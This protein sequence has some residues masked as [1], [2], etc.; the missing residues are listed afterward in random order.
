MQSIITQPDDTLSRMYQ[1]EASLQEKIDQTRKAVTAPV[2]GLVSFYLDG[3]ETSITV[4]GIAAMTPDKVK[5]LRDKILSASQSFEN[6]DIVAVGQPVCRIVNPGK[7][8]AVIVM[9]NSENRFVE[10]T[11]CDVT[12]DGLQKTVT[13]KVL[14]VATQGD[15]F[16]AVLEV[17]EGVKEI[18]SLRLVGGH[19]GQDIEGFRVPLN[20]IFEENGH[21]YVG[22]KGSGSGIQRVEVTILGKDGRYA[23]VK[24]TSGEGALENG[25]PLAKP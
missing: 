6:Q 8:Y 17:P 12:F 5:A 11:D 25:L 16:L 19:L 9:N 24:E 1:Q 23:I 15:R 18:I 20:M 2:A 13:T 7:W 4:D 21:A 14:H 10:G 22:I 3:Y